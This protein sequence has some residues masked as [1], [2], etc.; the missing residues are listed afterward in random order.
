MINKD[1]VNDYSIKQKNLLSVIRLVD[2]I[3]N[4]NVI[5]LNFCGKL[6]IRENNLLHGYEDYINIDIPKK[7]TEKLLMS[8]IEEIQKELD[9]LEQKIK[10]ELNGQPKNIS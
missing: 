1:L 6:L 4:E 2:K 5:S 3:K 8:F 10:L 9:E 7:M